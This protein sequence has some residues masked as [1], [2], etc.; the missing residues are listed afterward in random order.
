MDSYKQT[1]REI[2]DLQRFAIK[3]GLENITALCKE[4]NDPYVKYPVIHIAGT[5][6]KGSTA[7]FLARFLEASG[8]KTG[9]F[10]SPHLSDYRE[11][12]TINRQKIE[13]QFIMNFWQ[14]MRPIILQRKATF[15]DTTTAMAFDY[16]A[17]NEVDVAVIETGLG[18][19]LDSTNIVQPE[20]AVITPIHFDHTKQLGQTLSEIAG[21]K[22]G[23][24]KPGA[25]VF[26][27]R[28]QAESLNV[29]KQH[30]TDGQ[31]FFYLP[32]LSAVTLHSA[33]LD[34]MSFTLTDRLRSEKFDR[35]TTRQLGAFQLDNLAL[36]YQVY[37]KFLEH[38]DLSFS[39]ERFRRALE[40]FLWPGRLQLVNQKPPILFDVSHNLQG[41]QNTVAEVRKI[42]NGRTINILIG[43][44]NDKNF[45]LIADFLSGQGFTLFITEP[46]THRRLPAEQLADAFGA[47]HEKV[48][49][50]K[51]PVEAFRHA[52]QR[53]TADDL[54]LVTGSH[55]LIGELMK[56]N[57]HHQE[58]S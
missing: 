2:Y 7:A 57:F 17:R 40:T 37:R 29:L 25:D 19:R 42:A 47:L 18:G 34:G 55:Y 15:F 23:I 11:R 33:S 27:A 16:F 38:H 49:V 52:R 50:I 44:V 26:S 54:L 10:T 9:L 20:I 58:I 43:L 48:V 56:H 31:R 24:I 3:L 39:A 32:D 21:E 12:I 6:G 53:L 30:L 45:N 8:L 14:R 35:L 51:N 1:I 5:N 4:L 13:P 36:A 46:E 41:L 28:Q 22:A